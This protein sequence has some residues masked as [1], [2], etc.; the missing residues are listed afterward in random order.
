MEWELGDD[1][2]SETNGQS[3]ANESEKGHQLSN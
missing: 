2:P 1:E 3:P